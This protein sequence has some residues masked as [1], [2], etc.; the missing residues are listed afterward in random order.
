MGE[1]RDKIND[2][3]RKRAGLADRYSP[4]N[5]GNQFNYQWLHRKI[6]AHLQSR[7]ESLADIRLLDLGAGELFWTEDMIRMGL[8]TT[9]CLGSDLLFWRLAEGRKKGRQVNAVTSSAAALPF[10]SSSFDLVSQ[11][12]MMTSVPDPAL[13]PMIADEMKRVLRPGGYILWYDFRYNNPFNRHTQAIG[14]AEI[15]RLFGEWPIHCETI[16]LLP[17][18]ARKIGPVFYP[19]LKF[20]ATLPILRTHYLALIGPKG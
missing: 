3:F 15:G 6:L 19:L 16:T 12:T 11:L 2:V 4:D 18:M 17:P 13:K 14:R 7:F 5:R 8:T 9:N 20:A 10:T 1:D